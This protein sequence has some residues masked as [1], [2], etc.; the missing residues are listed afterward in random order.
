MA[1]LA[2]KVVQ[3]ARSKIGKRVYFRPKAHGECWDL[4]EKALEKSGAQTSTK[5]MG[6]IAANANYEWGT[7]VGLNQIK[8][9]YIVQ[10]RNHRNVIV[11]RKNFRNGEWKENKSTVTRAHHTAIVDKILPQGKI[12]LLEQNQNGNTR[13]ARNEVFFKSRT[14]S[15]SMGTFQLVTTVTVNG[16]AWFYKPKP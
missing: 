13:V 7:K 10:F 4:A 9:G 2:Q 1:T 8:P 5:I 11:I 12:T 14:W 3:Y 15:K 16:D 6:S